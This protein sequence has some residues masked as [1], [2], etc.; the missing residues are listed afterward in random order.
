VA[1]VTA[2]MVKELRDMTS[3]GFNDCRAALEATNG[4][5][6]EAA[7]WLRKKGMATAGKKAGREAREGVVQTYMH[8]NGRLAVVVEVNCETDFVARNEAFK[9]FAKDLALH[10]ANLGP[11]YVR[12][13]E[14]PADS[15]AKEK[16]IQL[17][18]TIAEGK[19]ANVAEKIVEGRLSK[20]YEEVVLMD[21]PWMHDDS[22]RVSEVLTTLVA[23]IKENIIINRFSRYV[24]GESSAVE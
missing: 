24:L 9:Q 3:A 2:K 21:Q 19:P 10:I 17:E 5:M 1:E 18:K 11:K 7:D 8:H 4:N 20:W 16:Q 6:S 12:R 13:E 22:K 14:I 15:L 23:E